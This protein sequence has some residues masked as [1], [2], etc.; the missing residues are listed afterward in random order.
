MKS[1]RLFASTVTG[2]GLCLLVLVF[3][4][5]HTGVLAGE[6]FPDTEHTYKHHLGGLLLAL[7]VSLHVIFIGLIIQKKWLSPPMARFA[8]VGIVSSG[9][10]LGASLLAKLFWLPAV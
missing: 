9:L 7:P 3:W 10:W 4:D 2:V 6:F 5:W 8:W 1:F